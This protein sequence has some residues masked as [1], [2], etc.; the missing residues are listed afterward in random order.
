VNTWVVLG[1]G[2]ALAAS[3]MGSLWLLQLRTHDA[4]PVDVGWAYGIGLLAI[5]DALLGRGCVSQ[6]L[7]EL[8]LVVPWSLRLG[9]YV[10]RRGVLGREGEDR[11][12]AEMRRR[13]GASTNRNFLVFFEFQALLVVVFS[14]PS[15]LVSFDHTRRIGPLEWVGVAVWLVGVLGEASADRQLARFKA[16]P[17]NRGRTARVGLWR[18]S[19]HPNYFF[20]WLIW[21]GL[22]LVALAAPHGAVGLVTPVLLLVLILFVTGIPPSEQQALRSRGE[23]YRRYQ[24]ETSVFVPWFPKR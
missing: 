5:L 23:D 7:L 11:R 19:R 10:L 24:Q 17:A 20:E 16:E 2:A 12:Y 9:T 3:L 4:T 13:Y 21:V 22:A 18:Y 14:L 8:L 6:R 1:I 15:L